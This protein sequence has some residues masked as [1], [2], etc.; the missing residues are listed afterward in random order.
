MR[1]WLAVLALATVATGALVADAAHAQASATRPAPQRLT[2]ERIFAA[3]DLGGQQPRSLKLSPDGRL[4]TFLRPR[5]DDRFRLDLWARDTANGQ[6][7]MLVDSTRVGS[8][9]ALSEA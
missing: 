1:S 9:A 5:A 3:P 4:L 7:R 6:E 2:L 8:G